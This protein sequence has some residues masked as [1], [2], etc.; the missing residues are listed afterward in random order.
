MVYN[1]IAVRD[2]RARLYHR[3]NTPRRQAAV[4]ATKTLK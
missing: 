4:T 1:K 2:R 3:V